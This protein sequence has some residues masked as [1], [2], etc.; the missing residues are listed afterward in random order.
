MAISWHGFDRKG[1]H[2]GDSGNC[3]PPPF[4]TESSPLRHTCIARVTSAPTSTTIPIS[5]RSLPGDRSA[6]PNSFR[7][8]HL[9]RAVR[10]IV[11]IR[12]RE[13][14][15]G[16]AHL[17]VNFQTPQDAR[18][19]PVRK[20]ADTWRDS[21]IQITRI[22]SGNSVRSASLRG[23]FEI[24]FQHHRTLGRWFRLRTF[25]EARFSIA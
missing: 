2:A 20:P 9:R 16:N 3:T 4:R 22:A 8:S 24:G 11:H 18:I 10:S 21:Y 19:S 7:L 14:A 12:F 13:S 5:D 23:S 25:D 1:S 17:N 6:L 15:R